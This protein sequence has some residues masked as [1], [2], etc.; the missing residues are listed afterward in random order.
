MYEANVKGEGIMLGLPL[1][2]LTEIKKKTCDV[3]SLGQKN[4]NVKYF[5]EQWMGSVTFRNVR[6]KTNHGFDAENERDDSKI[7]AFL[8]EDWGCST[9]HRLG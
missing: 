4:S 2:S 1:D 7:V 3:R 8:Q 5:R 9:H 6:S